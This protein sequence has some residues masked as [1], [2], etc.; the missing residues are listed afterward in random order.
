MLVHAADT[1]CGKSNFDVCGKALIASAKLD[2][3][4]PPTSTKDPTP[5]ELILRCEFPDFTATYRILL[6]NMANSTFVN[7]N[8]ELSK[9]CY[10]SIP[11]DGEVMVMD[12]A[13]AV[14]PENS[15]AARDT[16]H[17]DAPHLD[18]SARNSFPRTLA[19]NY[20]FVKYLV[21]NVREF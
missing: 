6:I 8:N 13:L 11:S 19:N 18:L 16:A 14:T 5:L 4:P 20:G 9:N 12:A 7:N 10:K 3:V 17:M 2:P 1:T 15:A 21:V